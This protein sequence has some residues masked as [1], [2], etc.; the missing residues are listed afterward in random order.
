MDQF[1]RYWLGVLRQAWTEALAANNWNL[2]RI[3]RR[4][5][6]FLAF[7]VLLIVIGEFEAVQDKAQLLPVF[8]A[9]IS[10]VL[11]G[12]LAWRVVAIPARMHKEQSAMIE[13]LKERKAEIA[14]SEHAFSDLSREFQETRALHDQIWQA[15]TDVD[16]L[17]VYMSIKEWDDRVQAK[18]KKYAPAEAF[19]FS[20][21][22]EVPESPKSLD[23]GFTTLRTGHTDKEALTQ[24]LT[25]KRSKLR[26]IVMRL[27]RNATGQDEG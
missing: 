27:E 6:L 14:R 17:N 18:I 24:F 9:A 26:L 19:A 5:V 7:G 16:L 25:A 21:I 13:S 4:A 15:S 20:S 11:V 22:A 23:L 12:E 3:S 10:L 2:S 8:I 1:L